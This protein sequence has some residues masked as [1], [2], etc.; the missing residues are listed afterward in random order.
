MEDKQTVNDE[1]SKN[2]FVSR[3]LSI[4][5]SLIQLEEKRGKMSGINVEGYLKADDDL[6]GFA[7][8]TE[9]DIL[10]EITDEIENDEDDTDPSQSLLTFQE[11]LQ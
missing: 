9:D 1:N 7:G 8:V 6:M 10:S 3:V 4:Q 5:K 2:S 11:A